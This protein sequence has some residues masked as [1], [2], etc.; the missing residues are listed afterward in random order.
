MKRSIIVTGELLLIS[1]IIYESYLLIIPWSEKNLVTEQ[2]KG[3]VE[4]MNAVGQ[5]KK[6]TRQSV[7]PEIV[8]SLFGWR[9]REKVQAWVAIPISSKK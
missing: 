3:R 2:D 6:G 8:A 1:I 4:K 9:K 5:E 7:P